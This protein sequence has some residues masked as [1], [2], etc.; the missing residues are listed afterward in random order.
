MLKDNTQWFTRAP[1][2]W[3]Q[4]MSEQ[5]LF[6]IANFD[7]SLPQAFAFL[8]STKK[9][10]NKISRLFTRKMLLIQPAEVS[11]RLARM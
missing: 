8:H 3:H 5:H 1:R 11:A 2:F 4:T 6:E 7:I 10:L 9:I